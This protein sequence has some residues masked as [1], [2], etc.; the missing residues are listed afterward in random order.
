MQTVFGINM[1]ALDKTQPKIFNLMDIL[2]AFILHRREVVTRRTVF[3][4]KK[5]RE[6]AHILEGLAIALVNI[7]PII[8]MIKASK[9]PA[10]AKVSLTAQGWSLGDVAEMLERSGNDAARPDWLEPEF[11]IRDGL[12][13]LTEQQAQAILDLR[14]NKLTGLEHDKILSEYKELLNFIAEL[15]HI[16]NSPERLMEIIREE[17]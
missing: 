7:D 5:A 1:V 17:L 8:A 12:Y 15:L 9:S 10:D 14:L 3:E 11:G 6:R 16:L 2:K 4:L 13:Y